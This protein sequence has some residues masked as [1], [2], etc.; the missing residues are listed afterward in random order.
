[1]HYQV[2]D[3]P[4]GCVYTENPARFTW[5]PRTEGEGPYRIEVR[6]AGQL[7]YRFEGIDRNFFTPDCV[8]EPGAYTYRVFAGE[9][10]IVPEKAF[11]IAE[12]A[13]HTPL[14]GRAHRYDA[15]GGHP[16]I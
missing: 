1:M 4:A 10:E 13:V 15:I 6:R 11:S 3:R 7:A 2:Y 16:R 8:M 14:V 9:E 12:D 5:M